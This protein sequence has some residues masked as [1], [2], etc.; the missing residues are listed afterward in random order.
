MKYFVEAMSQK[1]SYVINT[2]SEL[3]HKKNVFNNCIIKNIKCL[4]QVNESKNLNDSFVN[5]FLMYF[6]KCHLLY[7]KINKETTFTPNITQRN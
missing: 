1:L 7:K 2:Y 6:L 4:I 5:L 3:F